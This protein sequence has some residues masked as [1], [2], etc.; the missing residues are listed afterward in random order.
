[1]TSSIIVNEGC[2]RPRQAPVLCRREEE[3]LRIVGDRVDDALAR[4]RHCR[5]NH[6]KDARGELNQQMPR[7]FLGLDVEVRF[8]TSRKS[9]EES[10]VPHRNG[11][12]GPVN[13]L[14]G[15]FPSLIPERTGP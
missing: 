2:T 5:G 7:C 11:V 9:I 1:M 13:Y 12:R 6:R 15:K 8:Q 10:A 4:F 14:L 3:K